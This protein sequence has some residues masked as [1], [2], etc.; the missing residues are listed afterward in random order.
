MSVKHRLPDYGTYF[1]SLACLTIGMLATIGCSSETTASPART[2]ATG[3]DHNSPEDHERNQHHR[4]HEE[5]NPAP[6]TFKA[7]VEAVLG[8]NET[9]RRA[10]A[11]QDDDAADDRL[12]EIGHLLKGMNALAEKSEMTYEQRQLVQGAVA[13]LFEAFRAVD[14]TMHG[15]EGISYEEASIQIDEN[16]EVLKNVCIRT[17]S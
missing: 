9:I 8:I 15:R 11:V 10:F 17:K 13:R 1:L 14:A 12:H 16:L 7:A 6:E 2:T 5:E 3:G 4:D